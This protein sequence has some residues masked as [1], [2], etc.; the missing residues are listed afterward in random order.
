MEIKIILEGNPATKKNS[1]Q[2]G[3][4]KYTGRTFLTQNRRYKEYEKQCL[5]QIRK[6]EIE[7]INEPVNVR[8]V[9]YRDSLRRCDLPNLINATLDILVKGHVISDDNFGIVES[10]DGSRVFIDKENPRVEIIIKKN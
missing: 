7:E 5:M 8:C 1:M 9:Y 10:L 4:N 2:V 3:H 6:L